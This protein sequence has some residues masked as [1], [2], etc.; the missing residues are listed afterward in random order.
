MSEAAMNYG[1]QLAE[2]KTKQIYAHPTD[3]ALAF[4]TQKDAISAGDG[5]R[6][7]ALPGK[8]Q[9]SSQ[10]AANVFRLL[11]AHSVPTHFVAAPGAAVMLVR[12]CTMI[13]LE[14]V[15]RRLATGSYL[16]RVRGSVEGQRFDPPLVEF[17]VKDDANHDPQ[18]QPHAIPAGGFA[19]ATEV[20][21]ITVLG[22]RVF[23]LLE[24]AWSREQ[25]TLVDLKIE[26]GRTTDGDLVVAD[27]IDNDSWRLWP[28]GDKDRMLDKQIYRNM[29]SVDQAGL[30]RMLAKYREVAALTD[31]FPASN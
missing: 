4:M 1:T 16:R 21:N 25:I 9:L 13:P 11:N 19:T 26:F 29:P 27:M 30:D 6:R 3:P 24:Q 5:A 22:L 20:T 31:K 7:D 10:T 17:F 12:R 18:I 28:A 14:V 23:Q 8:G 15:M 2:G